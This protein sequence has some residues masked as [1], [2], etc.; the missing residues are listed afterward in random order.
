MNSQAA[1]QAATK[2]A[3]Q[4]AD[5]S[6]AA[7]E[8]HV[9]NFG[10]GANINP[11]KLREKRNM[12]PLEAYCGK[13]KN[14]RLLFNHRG[15]FGNLESIT[16]TNNSKQQNAPPPPELSPVIAQ[17]SEVHGILLRLTHDD[18]GRMAGMEH[19]YDAKEVSVTSYDGVVRKALAF[20]TNYRHETLE[21]GLLPTD[22][23]V[24]LIQ[25]GAKQMGIDASYRKWL[26]QIPSVPDKERGQEYY[27]TQSAPGK[28]VT[29]NSKRKGGSVPS[30]SRQ[31][32][33]E[34]QSSSVQSGRKA[35]SKKRVNLVSDKHSVYSEAGSGPA[36]IFVRRNKLY[37]SDNKSDSVKVISLEDNSNND[38]TKAVGVSKVVAGG[39]GRGKKPNQLNRP[40]RLFVDELQQYIYVV[41]RNNARVQ[42]W[43]ITDNNN[44]NNNGDN[45]M[46][47]AGGNEP[48]S[49][50]SQLD[51]PV[52]VHV[53]E[54]SGD[55]YVSDRANHR[56]VMW[57]RN[58]K[59]GRV[60]AG[61]NGFGSGLDQLGCPGGLH[62]TANGTVYVSD[63]ANNRIM[64]WN[65]NENRGQVVAGGHGAGDGTAQLYHPLGIWVSDE[66]DI[67]VVA[68]S[69]GYRVQKFRLSSFTEDDDDDSSSEQQATSRMLQG[70][71]IAGIT[72]KPGGGVIGHL[73]QPMSV[74]I[75][76]N[77]SLFV[78]DSDHS[79]V[80][81]YD[82][83]D[84][85][86][87]AVQNSA[88]TQPQ[89]STNVFKTGHCT[90]YNTRSGYGFVCDSDGVS[91]FAHH[92]DII[93]TS[94]QYGYPTLSKGDMLTFEARRDTKWKWRGT[95]IRK[96]SFSTRT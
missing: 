88:Q 68:D 37:V 17:P 19:Q 41:D 4:A 27:Q 52:D 20:I 80:Q 87:S 42:Q 24:K 21:R 13:V 48:G 96:D 22:R 64:K 59:E 43:P 95:N 15:G 65:P 74:Q 53:I 77:G 89:K 78:A 71:T 54:Q 23:Y 90:K 12:Q 91:Y 84:Q 31:G 18:F 73:G 93:D 66:E 92:S 67:L 29:E 62:V 34:P 61:G 49:G 9:W 51:Q 82:E 69:L 36:G 56:V 39:N 46:T 8:T 50:L 30:S 11:Q 45:V 75:D 33:K 85:A 76:E 40:W 60:V 70:E 26:D 38:M 81:R 57:K 79:R 14:V 5:R 16:G 6:N 58:A 47:V 2:R 28:R 55:V 63:E 7:N 3:L 10:Y 83:R 1:R 32:G 44:S 94:V 35:V 72:G 25:T 86:I